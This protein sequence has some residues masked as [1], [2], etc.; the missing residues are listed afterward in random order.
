[1]SE[2]KKSMRAHFTEL[3]RER[4][5]TP[6]DMQKY[7]HIGDLVDLARK[8][9][10]AGCSGTGDKCEPGQDCGYKEGGCGNDECCNWCDR[11]MVSWD[12]CS[13]S[14]TCPNGG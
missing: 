12:T 3:L 14:Q 11:C 9:A 4:D 5:I 1:M 2:T 6:E 13:S 8:R 10:A 7:R